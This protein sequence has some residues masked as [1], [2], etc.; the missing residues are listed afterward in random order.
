MPNL[1]EE[2]EAAASRY[3]RSGPRIYGSAD[4][5]AN[6]IIT[7]EYWPR[8]K[9]AIEAGMEMAQAIEDDGSALNAAAKFREA[10]G[11]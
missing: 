1:I 10:I 8:L 5:R 4:I 7:S 2:I 9:S 11:K 3:W 6:E